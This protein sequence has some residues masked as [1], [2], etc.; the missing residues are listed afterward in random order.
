MSQKLGTV[1]TA[2]G[3]LLV[4]AAVAL[5]GCG[6]ADM[7]GPQGGPYPGACAD[8]GFAPRQCAAMVGRAATWSGGKMVDAETI[9]ILP[10]TSGSASI[11]GYMISRV[12]THLATGP[13]RLW[14]SG[15]SGSAA[16]DDDACNSDPTI[17]IGARHVD[18]DVPC[19]GDSD[20]PTGCA[21]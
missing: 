7:F 8:L 17:E 3:M 20:P 6:V 19:T 2:R 18:R 4:L 16:A 15:A 12:R 10:P 9:D 21:T 11:G 1:L 14:R 5:A 13:P